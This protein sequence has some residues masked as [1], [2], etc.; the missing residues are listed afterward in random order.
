MPSGLQLG[1]VIRTTLEQRFEDG[2]DQP[3]PVHTDRVP[4]Y[5]RGANPRTYQLKGYRH[6]FVHHTKKEDV[7]GE[8]HENRAECLF[9]LLKPYLR[10]F[11][12][13]S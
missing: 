2:R 12:G 5:I 13:I 10:M 4:W 7:R 3:P 6:A 1:L 8:V 9:S 11:R